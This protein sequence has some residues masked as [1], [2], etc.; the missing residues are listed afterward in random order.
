MCSS[1]L[2]KKN[3]TVKHRQIMPK[4]KTNSFFFFFKSHSP[5]KIVICFAVLEN[6]TLHVSLKIKFETFITY[7][8]ANFYKIFIEL[9]SKSCVL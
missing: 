9:D 3:A 5:N 7:L 6:I 2:E 1:Q 4:M 8:F